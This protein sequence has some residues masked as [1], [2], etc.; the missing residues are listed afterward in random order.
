MTNEST[1]SDSEV[2]KRFGFLRGL[3][4]LLVVLALLGGGVVVFG[5]IAELN[6]IG[7][8]RSDAFRMMAGI[9]GVVVLL[10][11]ASQFIK[12]LLAIEENTRRAAQNND[13]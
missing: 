2:E 10:L 6:D 7:H 5:A 12:V 9:T 1:S 8:I 13:E 4:V 11:V 3:S